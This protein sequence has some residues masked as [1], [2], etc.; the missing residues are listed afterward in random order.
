MRFDDNEFFI[1]DAEGN[2]KA[3]EDLKKWNVL[4]VKQSVN[5]VITEIIVCE[6]N[7]R[8]AVEQVSDEEIVISG[9]SYDYSEDFIN[10]DIQLGKSETFF[11]DVFGRV[12]AKLNTSGDGMEVCYLIDANI[13]DLEEE[14]VKLKMCNSTGRIVV[15]YTAQK[16][17]MD[18][19]SKVEPQV[20]ISNLQKGTE[21][22]LPQPI[23]VG[24]DED[25]KVK[26]IDTAYNNKPENRVDIF[27]VIPENG[28]NKNS[29]R[30]IYP[31][32]TM[33]YR[34]TQKTFDG[35]INLTDATVIYSVPETMDNIDEN[36]FKVAGISSLQ[37]DSQYNC[38]FYSL[39]ENS[40]YADICVVKGRNA[41]DL[42]K[43]YGVVTSVKYT[44]DDDNE[45]CNEI[46]F[47]DY[48]GSMTVKDYNT[49]MTDIKR[50]DFVEFSLNGENEVVSMSLVYDESS[51]TFELTNPTSTNF[52][53]PRRL[54]F[55]Y[56]YSK[57]N[58]II[59]ISKDPITGT[60]NRTN[61]ENHT[62]DRYKCYMYEDST[63]REITTDEIL[64][65]K[66]VGGSC[67]KVVIY[68]YYGEPRILVVYK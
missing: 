38:E 45:F 42:E 21:D 22:I 29:F 33:Y 37:G 17:W 3:L 1:E 59:S 24:Y 47:S 44:I 9:N 53:E 68:T 2:P 65:F 64:D 16:V 11:L 7:I 40:S 48:S 13:V 51:N 18:N 35:K 62:A 10:R 66:H 31:S 67:S 49:E 34:S 5:K 50:G 46:Q 32:G 61:L 41:I 55:G 52:N 8:G 39:G 14:A 27:S 6:D 20:I 23:M 19:V 30:L 36:D 57:E 60:I 4:S 25:G 43:K 15:A 58:N 26:K 28:E 56:V 63:L 54:L 12:V